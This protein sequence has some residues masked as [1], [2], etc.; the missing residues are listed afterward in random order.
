MKVELDLSSYTTITDLKNATDVD[1]WN[2]MKRQTC[3][4]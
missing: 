3:R 1:K 2:F 4:I